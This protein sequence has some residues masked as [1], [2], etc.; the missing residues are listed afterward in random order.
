MTDPAT[1]F[2]ATRS[3]RTRLKICG[4]R[5]PLQAA[6]IAAMDVDAIGVIAVPGSPRFL[7]EDQRSGVFAAARSAHAGVLGVVVTADP[8]ALAVQSLLP[9]HGHDV[10]QLHGNEC[11]ARCQDLRRQLGPE[12][13]LWKALRIRCQEDLRRAQDYADV[14]DAL[15]L[16]AWVPDQLGGTGQAIPLDWLAGFSPTLPWW[17]AG[18]LSPETVASVLKVCHPDGVD[19]SSGVEERPGWKNLER[20]RRLVDQVA[21]CHGS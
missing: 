5:D 9:G 3:R 4:L 11:A 2:A 1:A 7:S 8:D 13:G 20:V 19:A 16:D 21:A 15:L 18:G 17:L 6:A 10:V 12:M 14:V